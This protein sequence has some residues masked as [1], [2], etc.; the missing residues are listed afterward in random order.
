[1]AAAQAI[2]F[3]MLITH[4]GDSLSFTKI[5]EFPSSAVCGAAATAV[6]NA[7]GPTSDV[8][9]GCISAESIEALKSANR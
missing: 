2:F 5:K 7:I 4:A 6:H 8:E 3:L 9:I 1:M